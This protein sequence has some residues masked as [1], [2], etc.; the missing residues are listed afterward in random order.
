MTNLV[1]NAL[2]Y[3]PKNT[4]RIGIYVKFSEKFVYISVMDN[5][6]GIPEFYQSKIFQ[7]FTQIEG[8]EPGGSGLGLSISKEIIRAHG[9]TIWVESQHGAG[10]KFTF[11]LAT[12]L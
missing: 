12:A 2:R 9:G 11:T 4:G 7:K 8:Y 1:S 3:V 5:G 10:A 6:P